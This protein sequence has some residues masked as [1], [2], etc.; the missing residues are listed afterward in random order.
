MSSMKEELAESSSDWANIVEK[1]NSDKRCFYNIAE[2]IFVDLE[3]PEIRGRRCWGS[4]FG[5]LVTCGLDLEIQLFNP[6]SRTS[7]PLPSLRTFTHQQDRPV[8]F[9]ARHTDQLFIC[10]DLHLAHPKAVE[11]AAAPPTDA[12]Y[13]K[14]LVDLGGNICM[15]SRVIYPF[16]VTP[17]NREVEIETFLT[18]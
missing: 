2:E 11:F 16:G 13:R 17:V 14:Y 1:E 18:T 3:F 4:P 6:L 12:A 8:F 10:Q 15:L 7:L 5:W 9:A